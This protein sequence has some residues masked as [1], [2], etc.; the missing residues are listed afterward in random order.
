MKP[1]IHRFISFTLFIVI[2]LLSSQFSLAQN[3][4]LGNLTVI[5]N[6]S[7][8]NRAENSVIVNGERA[9][10]G[11]SIMSPSEIITT[12]PM[13]AKISL[14]KTGDVLL[15]WGSKMNLSF[16]NS[17]I[18]GELLTGSVTIKSEPNTTLSLFT[19]EG[20]ITFPVQNQ[21]NS[22]FVS[23]ENGKTI[24]NALQG[25]VK[26]NNILVSAGESYPGNIDNTAIP[27]SNT[28][29]TESDSDELNPYF[30]TGIVA[31]LAGVVLIVLTVSSN[32]DNSTV[33]PI[34]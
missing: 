32:D 30:L 14:P 21:V 5:K 18:S 1:F 26:F 17:S 6:G 10:N 13:S 34:R 29:I 22:V 20:T 2:L 9:V 7:S 33:S 28:Q 23:V 15:S 24:V 27:D 19:T 11:S 16:V 8:T 4:L 25:Q 31:A 12:A 3:K